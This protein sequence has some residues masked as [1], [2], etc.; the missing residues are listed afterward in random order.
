MFPNKRWQA[1]RNRAVY[2]AAGVHEVFADTAGGGGDV[3]ELKQ[4][5]STRLPS[6]TNTFLLSDK[7]GLKYST[8][9]HSNIWFLSGYMT[10]HPVL[11][12]MIWIEIA[13]SK[14]L[15]VEIYAYKEPQL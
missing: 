8:L 4:H 14:A 3:H 7:T 6:L 5:R 12:H 1:G 9:T 10:W 11:Y 2:P 15:F 13:F